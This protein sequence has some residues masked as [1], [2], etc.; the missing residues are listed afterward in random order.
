M[1]NVGDDR[2]VTDSAQFSHRKRLLK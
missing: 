2:K 1:V